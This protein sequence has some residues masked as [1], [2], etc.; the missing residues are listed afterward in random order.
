MQT[1]NM[2]PSTGLTSSTRHSVNRTV[3]QG[4]A[5]APLRQR[6]VRTVRA[7][8]ENAG[9]SITNSGKTKNPD[10]YEVLIANYGTCLHTLYNAKSCR[11]RRLEY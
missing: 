9:G 2:T 1:I 7:E 6:T 10:S 11:Q 3:F 8:N 4:R 5:L